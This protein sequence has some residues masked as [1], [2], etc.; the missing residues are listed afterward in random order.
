MLPPKRITRSAISLD[1]VFIV[2]IDVGFIII[3]ISVEGA[4]TT[5]VFAAA[6]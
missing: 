2:V 5:L 4:T 1:V 3:I 6:T